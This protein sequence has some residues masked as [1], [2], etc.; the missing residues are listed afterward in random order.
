MDEIKRLN[1]KNI[2]IIGGHK[3][4]SQNIED[5]LKKTYNTSRIGGKDR[6]D[7][8]GIIAKNIFAKTDN[9][10]KAIIASGELYPDALCISTLA[11]KEN[12]PILLTGKKYLPEF[13]S[14]FILNNKI[15]SLIYTG[16]YKTVDKIIEEKTSKL[17]AKT[18]I[19]YGGYDRFETSAI[20]AEAIRKDSKY[21][22]YASGENFADAL[23]SGY[24]GA[25]LESPTLLVKRDILPNIIKATMKNVSPDNRL[26]IGGHNSISNSV[27]NEIK[28]IK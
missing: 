10:N 23:I 14:N 17:G 12:I 18:L 1:A 16:G 3:S 8:A 21:A 19:R 13:T 9:H 20:I 4:V 26:I 15:N 2:I 22:L 6:F 11:T 7:T 25:K 24:L 27:I 5:Y 28:S